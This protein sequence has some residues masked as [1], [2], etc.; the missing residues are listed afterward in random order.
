MASG[1][2]EHREP[3]VE[4]SAACDPPLMP[5]PPV[6]VCEPVP[7]PDL[8]PPVRDAVP[9]PGPPLVRD[10][11]PVSEPFGRFSPPPSLPPPPFDEPFTQS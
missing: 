10:I 1:A 6:A 3:T 7:L 9:L 8:P 5:P 11:L 2:E 4:L